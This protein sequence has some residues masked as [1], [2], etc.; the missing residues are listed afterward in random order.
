METAEA[1]LG[2]AGHLA[3]GVNE[4]A[5]R[6][7]KVRSGAMT[8]KGQAAYAED[9]HRHERVINNQ[10]FIVISDPLSPE[11]FPCGQFGSR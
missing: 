5:A 11:F 7:L 1:V 9:G 3:E 2:R 4:K 8:F 10:E 6:S